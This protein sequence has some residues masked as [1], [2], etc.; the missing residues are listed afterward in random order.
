MN[1]RAYLFFNPPAQRDQTFQGHDIDSRGFTLVEVILALT[2]F[3]LMGGILYGAFSLGHSAVEKSEANSARNQKQRAT[4]DLLG[5]YVRSSF[6]Y[7]ESAQDPAIYFDGDTDSLTFVSA[8]SQGMGGRGMAKIQISQD[9]DGNG[10]SSIKV[11][12]TTPVRISTDAGAGMSHRIV[13]Q[14]NV[15]E[16]RLA[17][18]D[19]QS[20]DE[21]WEDR[22]DG[23]E[24]RV[25][26][27]AV[28]FSYVAQ[29]GK[30][31]RWVFPVMMSV[32]AQ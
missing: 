2:I 23:K 12:E 20:E 5:S 18:L 31:V 30:E 8:Y 14:D 25:L 27:R 17:Y 19:P 6:P 9:E 1:V 24:R 22:W 21:K 11:E 3:A 15:K 26:P 16:F 10:R 28:R 7:R 29:N 13:L 4:A 32:L